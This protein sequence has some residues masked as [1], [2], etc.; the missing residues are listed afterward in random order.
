MDVLRSLDSAQGTHVKALLGFSLDNSSFC[1]YNLE[2]FKDAIRY[3]E[4]AV[5]LYRGLV[6]ENVDKY[7]RNLGW[8]LYYHAR[9]LLALDNLDEAMKSIEECIDIE[10]RIELRDPDEICDNLANSLTLR[11]EISYRLGRAGDI[12]DALSVT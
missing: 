12:Q 2:R 1:C 9:S 10:S 4:E 3:A 11:A 7:E 8:S 6:E 5:Q